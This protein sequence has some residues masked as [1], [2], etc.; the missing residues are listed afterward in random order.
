MPDVFLRVSVERT[1][2]AGRWTAHLHELGAFVHGD[3]EEELLHREDEAVQ[4]LGASFKTLAELRAFLDS[5][6]IPH[7]VDEVS[8]VHGATRSHKTY[9]TRTMKVLA[10][11]SA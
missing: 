2:E 9:D 8:V 5:R 11:A 6:G 10:G 4:L 3:S 1:E 7:W